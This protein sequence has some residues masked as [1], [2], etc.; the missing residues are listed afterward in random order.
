ML[1]LSRFVRCWHQGD[2]SCSQWL[3]GPQRHLD[4]KSRTDDS[5]PKVPHLMSH[6]TQKHL[7]WWQHKHHCVQADSN[8]GGEHHQD[9]T[10]KMF[11]PQ[12]SLRLLS[13]VVLQPLFKSFNDFLRP[14][15]CSYSHPATPNPHARF[16]PST[17][18][19]CS[20]GV[21]PSSTLSPWKFFKP[22]VDRLVRAQLNSFTISSS[23]TLPGLDGSNTHWL[24]RA[25]NTWV[26]LAPPVFISFLNDFSQVSSWF[27]TC[28]IQVSH[29]DLHVLLKLSPTE[30]GSC[31]SRFGHVRVIQRI[32][33][34]NDTNPDW[35]LIQQLMLCSFFGEHSWQVWPQKT[36]IF[37]PDL[38][39]CRLGKPNLP[40][41]FLAQGG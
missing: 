11:S 19:T 38:D 23:I 2:S 5:V 10:K 37:S 39:F 33:D 6:P 9:S 29:L 26:F 4:S 34:Q 7:L 32:Y 14:G 22:E 8:P 15:S 41:R 1:F 16:W 24:G 27:Q 18:N 21:Q 20:H 25:Q 28:W 36:S 3:L 40:P 30:N 35:S 17:K 13:T 31:E 12:P